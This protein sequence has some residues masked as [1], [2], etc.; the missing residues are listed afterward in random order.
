MHG[1]LPHHPA[2][3]VVLGASAFLAPEA[4]EAWDAWFRWRQNGELRDVSVDDTWDRVVAMLSGPEVPEQAATWRRQLRGTLANWQLLLDER[5]VATAG[6]GTAAWDT[7][8]LSASLNLATFVDDAFSA[9]A[10]FDFAAFDRAAQLAVQ[11]LDNA[12]VCHAPALSSQTLRIGVIGMADAL[13]MQGYCYARRQALVFAQRIARMLAE[14]TLRASAQLAQKRG[15]LAFS[16]ENAVALARA[17]NMPS[18]LI[19]SVLEHGTRF[20]A[21]TAI[22]SQPRLALLANNVSDAIDPLGAGSPLPSSVGR[23][24]GRSL[25]PGFSRHLL[26]HLP[27]TG[28]EGACEDPLQT[29]SALSQLHMRCA[30]QAWIDQPIDYPCALD[31]L[32]DADEQ[33]Q[34]KALATHH[35]IG[36]MQWRPARRLV[37]AQT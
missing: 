10:S 37:H 28:R 6:T 22:E 29:H 9:R 2:G 25:S 32:P 19:Q 13:H 14:S 36:P 30:M 3:P 26:E 20:A 23:A 12:L 18:D 15:E 21:H 24:A 27:R 31:R 7:A 8:P 33:A 4:V 34:W 1:S 16:N 35:G 11:A 17:R 5:I